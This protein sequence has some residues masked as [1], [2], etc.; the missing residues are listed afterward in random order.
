MFNTND[1]NKSCN[2]SRNNKSTDKNTIVI[3]NAVIVIAVV[4]GEEY[5]EWPRDE[6]FM[7]S[8]FVSLQGGLGF[9][10]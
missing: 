7:G 2:S 6:P 8:C 1:S 4:V 10:V 3:I 5:N 9:R